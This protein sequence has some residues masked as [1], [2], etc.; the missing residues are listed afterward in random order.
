MSLA[1]VSASGGNIPSGAK[2]AGHEASSAGGQQLYVA[3]QTAVGYGQL[4]GKVRPGW[5]GAFFPYGGQELNLSSY[6]VLMNPTSY[7]NGYNPP[8]PN[9]ANWIGEP[10]VNPPTEHEGQGFVPPKFPNGTAYANTSNGLSTAGNQV[11]EFHAIKCGE[12]QDGTPLFAALASYQGGLHP[13]KVRVGLGGANISWGGAE[14]PGLNPYSV[15]CDVSYGFVN[16]SPSGVPPNSMLCGTDDDGGELYIARSIGQ[17]PGLQLGKARPDGWGGNGCLI[18]YAGKEVAV[19]TYQVLFMNGGG[20]GGN[21]VNASGGSI[22]DGAVALGCELDGTPLFAAK[23]N[24]GAVGSGIQLGK[25]RHGFQGAYIPYNGNEVV[26]T[27]YW[28]LCAQ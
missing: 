26:V 6:E 10:S 22:P 20:W 19:Q 7:P 11:L 9:G 14:I 5:T 2:P 24:Q 4:L 23:T 17:L 1:W 28:V 25:V 21:W 27:D 13:G 16:G 3:R 12:E 18:S 15:I 8:G